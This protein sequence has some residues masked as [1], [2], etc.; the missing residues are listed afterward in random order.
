MVAWATDITNER[1]SWGGMGLWG[2]L[3]EEGEVGQCESCDEE[4]KIIITDT[5]L[6]LCEQCYRS[7]L[8]EAEGVEGPECRECGRPSG[9]DGLCDECAGLGDQERVDFPLADEDFIDFEGEEEGDESK[10]RVTKFQKRER[11][12]ERGE[13]SEEK[14]AKKSRGKKEEG[15]RRD[16][17]QGSQKG[18]EEEGEGG[19]EGKRRRQG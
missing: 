11:E 18:G 10:P 4:G 14:E 7:M 8:L 9:D 19:R 1:K 16:R 3:K 2:T 5:K 17:E 12:E 6:H 13:T 15:S